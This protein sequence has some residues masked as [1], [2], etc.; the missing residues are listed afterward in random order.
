MSVVVLLRPRI[1]EMIWLK[2]VCV[3]IDTLLS[4]GLGKDVT[5]KCKRLFHRSNFSIY[6]FEYIAVILLINWRIWHK[7]KRTCNLILFVNNCLNGNTYTYIMWCVSYI[8]KHKIS[9]QFNY[10]VSK[11]LYVVIYIVNVQS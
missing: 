5:V 9:T 10:Y 6:F 11:I 1:S 2:N 4:I 7:K 3:M 8:I